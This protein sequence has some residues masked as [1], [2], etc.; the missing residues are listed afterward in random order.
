VW[1]EDLPD[2]TSWFWPRATTSW[3]GLVLVVI[4]LEFALPVLSM[5]FRAVKRNPR[6]IALVCLLA[7]A[8][9]WLDT[10]WLTVPSVR[11][12]GFE[13]RLLDLLALAGEGGIWLAAVLLLADRLPE[14]R[15][16]PIAANAHG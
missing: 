6:W 7:L 16:V 15:A 8:G 11:P 3:R 13:L 14:R 2:E 4:A 12:A 9:Q 5:L 1:A 10:L